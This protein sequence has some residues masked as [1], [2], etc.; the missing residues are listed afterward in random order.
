MPDEKPFGPPRPLDIEFL[1]LIVSISGGF[2]LLRTAIDHSADLASEDRFQLLSEALKRQ[3]EKVS[4]QLD[5][6]LD[7]LL[8]SK[9]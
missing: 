8:E 3:E 4:G 2:G 7:R 5:S 6:L 9:K 1:R